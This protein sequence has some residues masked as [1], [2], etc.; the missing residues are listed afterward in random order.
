MRWWRGGVVFSCGMHP[1]QVFS[2]PGTDLGTRVELTYY[3]WP[4]ARPGASSAK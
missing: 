4:G 2:L 3:A 1:V